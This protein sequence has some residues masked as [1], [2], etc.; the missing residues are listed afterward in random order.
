MLE[1]K[2]TILEKIKANG[3]MFGVY[4]YFVKKYHIAKLSQ[5]PGPALMAG[6]VSRNFT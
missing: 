1:E 3:T 4:L 2:E 6:L 5:A